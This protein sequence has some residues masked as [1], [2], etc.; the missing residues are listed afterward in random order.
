M[1]G[2]NIRDFGAICDVSVLVNRASVERAKHM[3]DGGELYLPSATYSWLA[4]DKL[5]SVRGKA[6]GYSLISQFVRDRALLIVYLP[7][8]YDELAR[9][10][11][12]TVDRR[13]PL[14]D[15]RA[16][17]LA[18]Y[19]KLP[20]LT[21]D[22]EVTKR[23]SDH[24]NARM[25]WQLNLHA[26]WLAMREALELYRELSSDVGG[27]L[28]QRMGRPNA[29][30]NA[31]EELQNHNK[32]NLQAVTAAL[33]RLNRARP[34]PGSLNFKY[35]TWDLMPIMREYVEQHVLQPE[36]MRELCERVL[37]LVATPNK[38]RMD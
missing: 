23:L 24:V 10:L 25:L 12:F 26:N 29:F 9:R 34:N 1:T 27:Y 20:L 6:V 8:L 33:K 3:L 31:I 17:M 36:V 14:T 37:L 11:L 2:L 16:A 30:E 15:L 21:F 13:V 7:E 5:I 32:N 18:G 28:S 22:D 38:A 19:L 35:L 4:R